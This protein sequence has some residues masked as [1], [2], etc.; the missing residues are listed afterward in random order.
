MRGSRTGRKCGD[1]GG[2]GEARRGPG[3]VYQD[4]ML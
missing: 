1:G 4:Q 2:D 3:E